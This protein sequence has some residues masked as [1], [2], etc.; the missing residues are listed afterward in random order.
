MTHGVMSEM[1]ELFLKVAI[2]RNYQAGTYIVKVIF[3]METRYAC[4]ILHQFL[5]EWILVVSIFDVCQQRGITRDGENGGQ[6]NAINDRRNFVVK[7]QIIW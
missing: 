6:K 1:E 2:L 7:S 3:H 4:S 5:T